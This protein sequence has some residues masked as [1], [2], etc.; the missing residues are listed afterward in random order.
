MID[1]LAIDEV[2]RQTGLTSRA[3]RF[4]EAR[5]L[6]KP[7]RTYS[8]RRLFD[9]TALQRIHQITLLKRA[10]LSLAQIKSLFEHRP[11]DLAMLLR[12][13]MES[14]AE[15]S[16]AIE[17]A[18][19][20]LGTALSRI[21]NGEHLDV[22]TLCSLIKNGE[23]LMTEQEQWKNVIDRYW[24]ADEQADWSSKTAQL[25]PEENFASADYLA[26]WR[27]LGSR[28]EA[29]L[30]ME[31]D[32]EQALGFVREWFTLLEPFSRIS[33]PEMW[34]GTVQFYE[35][36]PEWEGDM[37]AGFSS[38]VWQFIQLA[39]KVQRAAGHDVGPL[40]MFMKNTE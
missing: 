25:G 19:A 28:I 12:S 13:Q 18:Q 9:A 24:T 1:T 32:S 29:A 40:P 8:G 31:P 6:V 39:T 2:V 7:L 38:K 14:L 30:P 37:D 16:R 35:K 17:S 4:Y 26:K 27:D 21:E 10:G 3:L 22:A 20:T 23:T 36:M 34:Q 33:T 5:G 15:Q 11:V